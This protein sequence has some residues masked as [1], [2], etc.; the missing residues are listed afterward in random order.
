ML[1]KI[2]TGGWM[3]RWTDGWM[4]AGG[5]MYQMDGGKGQVNSKKQVDCEK[6]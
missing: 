6:E 3:N 5:W 4:E 2:C 1:F